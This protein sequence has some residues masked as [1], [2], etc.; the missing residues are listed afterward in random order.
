M[1]SF[2]LVPT[3]FILAR[4][5]NIT[6]ES[7]ESN[8][9]DKEWCVGINLVSNKLEGVR[10]VDMDVSIFGHII[11]I[12]KPKEGNR[13][14]INSV[15]IVWDM[16]AGQELKSRNFVVDGEFVELGAESLETVVWRNARDYLVVEYE[17]VPDEGYTPKVVSEEVEEG[18]QVDII[19]DEYVESTKM[20]GRPMY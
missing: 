2:T 1:S 3:P 9:T 5:F 18:N 19:G 13:W 7:S 16:P 11:S 17:E 4:F 8:A 10:F 12:D 15:H 20:S 6:P 14:S